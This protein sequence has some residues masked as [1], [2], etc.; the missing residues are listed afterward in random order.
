MVRGL[1]VFLEALHVPIPI[2]HFNL[3]QFFNM[4]YFVRRDSELLQFC[5]TLNSQ[6]CLR[7]VLMKE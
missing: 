3:A 2:T 6:C 5:D 7:N 1:L 4:Q